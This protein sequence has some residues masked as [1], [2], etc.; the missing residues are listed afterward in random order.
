MT[1]AKAVRRQQIVLIKFFSS[2]ALNQPTNQSFRL[3]SGFLFVN[4]VHGHVSEADEFSHRYSFDL[5]VGEFIWTFERF[6]QKF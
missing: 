3:T 1:D 5:A 2:I 6:I 4:F